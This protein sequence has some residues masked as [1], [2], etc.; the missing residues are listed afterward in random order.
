[1]LQKLSGANPLGGTG[2][3]AGGGTY[4]PAWSTPPF[5]PNARPQNASVQMPSQPLIPTYGKN[6]PKW[7][8]KVSGGFNRFANGMAGVSNNPNL[9]PDENE[10]LAQQ[11]RMATMASLLANSGPAPVGTRG[12]LQPFGEAMLAGQVAGSR[13]A[14]DAAKSR[15]LQAQAQAQ[16][17]P[18]RLVGV[19]NPSDFTPESLAQYQQS[20]NPGDLVPV[21]RNTVNRVNPRDYTP[22]SLAKYMETGNLGDLVRVAPHQFQTDPAGGI[23]TLDP[24]SGQQVGTVVSPEEGS[25]LAAQRARSTAEASTIGEAQG[26]A[27]GSIMAKAQNA[28]GIQDILDIADPLIDVATGS[29]TGAAR[30]Q[31][32]AWF[33]F[34]TEGANATAQLKILEAGLVLG[35]PRMEGPQS[36]R[37]ALL[38]RE[39]AGQI[40][41]PSVPRE[42]K[43]AAMQTIR[44]LQQQYQKRGGQTPAKSLPE[45]V[46]EEDLEFTMQKHGLTREQVLERL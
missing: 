41:D 2:G 35:M 15:Y 37:D 14:E 29:A 30:D 17:D 27:L 36:D 11:Q 4:P 12:A 28:Q 21:E 32:A 43:K 38:Y 10:A 45:G 39:A 19:A 40:G 31:V 6:V 8:Q 22:E 33:G 46:T 42:Q 20:G 1:M 18:G 34:S 23:R 24:I 16:T 3:F 44:R 5:N 13:F 9:T 26:K 25:E 7:L